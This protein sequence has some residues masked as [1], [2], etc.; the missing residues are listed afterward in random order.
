MPGCVGLPHGAWLDWDAEEQLDRAGMENVLC[1]SL[2][3][4]QATSGYNNYN[5]NYELYEGAPLGADCDLPA[6]VVDAQR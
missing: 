2:A 3:V 4:G 5:C 6:R 1:G